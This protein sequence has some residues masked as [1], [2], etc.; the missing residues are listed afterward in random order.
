VGTNRTPAQD[1]SARASSGQ[2]GWW[3]RLGAALGFLI[4]SAA[5]LVPQGAPSS[6]GAL[7]LIGSARARG[8]AWNWFD[9]GSRGKY[10]YAGATLRVG[11]TQQWATIGW[12]AELETPLLLGLPDDA[13][14]PAPAGQLGLGGTYFAANDGNRTVGGHYLHLFPTFQGPIDLMLWGA[15]QTGMWGRLDHRAH[16]GAVEVG[17]QPD[18]LRWIRPWL[19]AGL[20]A[21]SGDSEPTDGRHETFFQ[22]LPTPQPHARFPFHKEVGPST[23]S[24]SATSADRPRGAGI[25]PTCGT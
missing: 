7:T 23:T 16:A 3:S 9:A 18:G 14:L 20:F 6:A 15:A 22:V 1:R 5:P 19:R 11:A 4:V 24:R 12:Q 13:V 2:L 10:V 17:I 25:W 21:S 8:E